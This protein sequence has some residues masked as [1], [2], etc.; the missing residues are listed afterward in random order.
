MGWRLA[1]FA[2]VV[3]RTDKCCTNMVLPDAVDHHPCSEGVVG[4]GNGFGELEPAAAILEQRRLA[5]GQDRKKS[6]GR[7]LSLVLLVSVNIN[8]QVLRFLLVFY[9]GQERILRGKRCLQL[10]NSSVQGVE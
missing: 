10:I 5:F 1:H 6:T 3:R 8:V 7:F 4:I 9:R 2:E